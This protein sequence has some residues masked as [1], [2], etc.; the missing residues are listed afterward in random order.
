MRPLGNGNFKL[1][2]SFEFYYATGKNLTESVIAPKGFITNFASIPA[3]LHWALDPTDKHIMKPSVIHDILYSNALVT[4]HKT[5]KIYNRLESDLL[6]FDM[7]RIQDAPTWKLV[8]T[9]L[10][11]HWFGWKAYNYEGKDEK[12]PWMR[13][14]MDKI[15]T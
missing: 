9:F 4:N 2:E 10:L 5:G 12:K 11:L 8:G 6:M 3:L 15:R 1:L 14:A 7:M 13:V